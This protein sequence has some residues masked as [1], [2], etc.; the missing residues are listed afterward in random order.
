MNG[1]ARKGL[2]ALEVTIIMVTYLSNLLIRYVQLPTFDNQ[3]PVF[4]L[5]IRQG[6]EDLKHFIPGTGPTKIQG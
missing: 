4:S 1:S 3:P 2:C 5:V 6:S